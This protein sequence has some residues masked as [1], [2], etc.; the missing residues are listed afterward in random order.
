MMKYWVTGGYEDTTFFVI[1][2]EGEEER[3]GH[4]ATL[5]EAYNEWPPRAWLTVG[6]C[7]AGYNVVNE[8]EEVLHQEP[9]HEN[10]GGPCRKA[11]PGWIE[12]VLVAQGGH[13]RVC[14]SYPGISGTNMGP[15]LKSRGISFSP[16]R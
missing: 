15:R 3:H 6:S 8:L 16:G 14:F 1:A 11:L 12:E 7:T 5:D 13:A 4:F 2:E 10:L 9:S